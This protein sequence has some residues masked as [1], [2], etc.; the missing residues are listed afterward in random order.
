MDYSKSQ[1]IALPKFLLTDMS[2]HKTYKSTSNS[3]K[4]R[5]ADKGD[6]HGAKKN[7]K[8][9][10]ILYCF[11]ISVS[12]FKFCMPEGDHLINWIKYSFPLK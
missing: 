11:R 1:V 6:I 4:G 5:K 12:F 7:A 2:L 3:F 10:I 8:K 9:I